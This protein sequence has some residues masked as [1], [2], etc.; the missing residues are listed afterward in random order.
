ME[1]CDTKGVEGGWYLYFRIFRSVVA[2][3]EHHFALF[4]SVVVTSK[5]AVGK[6]SRRMT[7]ALYDILGRCDEH[8]IYTLSTWSTSIFSRFNEMTGHFIRTLLISLGP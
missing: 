6:S 4:G 7:K 2:P 3:F 8:V 1:T 5:P